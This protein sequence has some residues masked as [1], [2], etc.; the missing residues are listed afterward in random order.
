MYVRC[1]LDECESVIFGRGVLANQVSPSR[2]L[3]QES[4]IQ[5]QRNIETY[6]IHSKTH[7]HIYT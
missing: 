1:V 5:G 6:T 7:T 2:R 4:H 3:H